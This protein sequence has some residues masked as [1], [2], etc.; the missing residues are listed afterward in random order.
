MVLFEISPF[1]PFYHSPATRR[2]GCRRGMPE[3]NCR[4]RGHPAME[5]VLPVAASDIFSRR[6]N[7]SNNIFNN[8]SINK[9]R[10]EVT[11]EGVRFTLP[12][13]GFDMSGLEVKV[14]D[15]A[16]KIEA[17]K[18]EKNEKGESVATR[19][20]RQVV[21]LPEGCD[22]DAV[23]TSF[24]ENGA[25][26]ISIPRKAEAIETNVTPEVTKE[27]QETQELPQ[28]ATHENQEETQEVTEENQEKHDTEEECRVLGTIPVMGF[29]PEE[30]SVKVIQDGKAFEVVGRHEDT[31]TGI[32][33]GLNRVYPIPADVEAD[34]I[35]ARMAKDGSEL[36]IVVP[37]A[38]K[39]LVAEPERDIP[40]LMDVE[41]WHKALYGKW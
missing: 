41:Q 38:P 22:K 34:K 37:L 23:E 32:F 21:S 9:L 17:R 16:L 25:L 18:E 20:M 28:E 30:L 5:L 4:W 7:S 40:I 19:M 8:N 11:D 36:R 26:A 6:S 27:S 12:L 33:S 2:G 3:N 35:E 10:Q 39:K 24:E 13:E 29:H 14:E 31:A 1:H 15:G